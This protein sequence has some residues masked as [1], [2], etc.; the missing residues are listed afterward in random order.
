MGPSSLILLP[1]ALL[2]TTSAQSSNPS[3]WASVAMV[4]HGERTPLLGGLQNTLTPQ[5]A[6]QLYAQGDAFRSRYLTS[7]RLMLNASEGRI[8]SR[9]PIQGMARN[10]LEHEQLAIL[11]APDSH[12]VAGANAFMQ[13]LYPPIAKAF[14]ADTGGTNISYSTLTGNS[15]QY[16][17]DGYQ[18]PVIEIL[19]SSDERSVDIRGNTECPQ[20]G[21]STTT[22]MQL[23]PD[24]K[25]LD[26]ASL[27][28]YLSLFSTPPLNDG[29]V[30]LSSASFWDA[31]NIQQYV[32]YRYS[33]EQ[34]IYDAM[35]DGYASR[36]EF[37]MTYARLQQLNM[38]S[39]QAVSG[40]QKGDMIRTIAG[41]TLARKVV[42][43]FRANGDH[44]G[45]TDKMTLMFSSHEPFMSFF[46]LARLHQG[47]PTLPSTF[48]N[49]PQNG[50][51]MVFE[52]IGD[53]PDT[54]GDDADAYPTEDNL[55]VRFL[56][57]ENADPNTPFKEYAL[58]G[59][60]DTEA[61]VPYSR[62]KQEMLNFGV[63]VSA[64]CKICGSVQSFCQWRTAQP[65]IGEAIRSAVQKPF[66]A[67][68][69]GAIIALAVLGLA[70]VA[71]ILFGGFRI[72]RPETPRTVP[73]PRRESRIPMLF[74]GL[75]SNEK[76][77][78]D[79]DLSVSRRG[80]HHERHGSWELRDGP[81]GTSGRTDAG[82]GK[83]TWSFHN[84]L[85][86]SLN[87]VMGIPPVKPREDV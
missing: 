1:S 41:R 80:S 83:G 73:R 56:Y 64:W 57:R 53:I 16:P 18:Y 76:M 49:I 30:P 22:G 48:W 27:P 58:F 38:T 9:F 23:D 24:M 59:L 14:A 77:A 15:T 8:T 34:A 78:S 25:K 4:M 84:K 87:G 35:K 19:G 36:N 5:G 61:R 60:A 67:G 28:G 72:Q 3:V 45:S 32:S 68:I 11:S 40:L 33:H 62:F 81:D 29:V 2:A 26:E 46:S 44:A 47:D 75:R 74:G 7:A 13:G 65:T 50:A 51:V 42:D 12:I 31:Y 66:V 82:V 20:W 21:I 37:L 43:A 55:Y 6:Q 70:A 71:A 63:D 52:L 17:L 69:I 39:N 79:P 10:V 54:A 86:G 85:V